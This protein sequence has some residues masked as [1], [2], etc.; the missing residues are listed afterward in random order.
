MFNFG[1]TEQDP[2]KA[3]DNARGVVNNGLM[4]GL[5]K[6]FMGQDFVNKA[7]AGMNM[8]QGALDSQAIAATG[9][10]A[11]GIVISIT[12]TGATI[13]DNPMVNLTLKATSSVGTQWEFTAQTVVS[14]LAIPRVG[15]TIKFKYNPMNP[16]QISVL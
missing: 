7:N 14:R 9:L 12:D 8:A 13:N 15:D 6:A 4:G 1:K 3:L 5:T 16:S 11:T 2:Q 10:D